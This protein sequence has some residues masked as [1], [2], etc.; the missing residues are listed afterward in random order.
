[1]EAI[2]AMHPPAGDRRGKRGDK[3]A[4]VTFSAVGSNTPSKPQHTCRRL[5]MMSRRIPIAILAALWLAPLTSLANAA[6]HREWIKTGPI[7]AVC[8]EA[9]A[10]PP[11]SGRCVSPR[12]LHIG[13]AD[14]TVG[15]TFPTSCRQTAAVTS[16]SLG[17]Q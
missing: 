4:A 16:T 15:P 1:M 6:A 7:A 12:C 5:E 11:A 14:D 2:A 17:P 10:S 13:V 8:E 3:E 9:L